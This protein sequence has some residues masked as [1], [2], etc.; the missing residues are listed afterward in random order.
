MVEYNKKDI[1]HWQTTVILYILYNN[2]VHIY[3]NRR[4][5][6]KDDFINDPMYFRSSVSWQMNRHQQD[7]NKLFMFVYLSVAP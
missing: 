2:S 4:P 1:I 5:L 7:T 6:I 3:K